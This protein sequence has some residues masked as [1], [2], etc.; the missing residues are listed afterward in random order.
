MGRGERE[1]TGELAH[2]GSWR[3]GEERE[4][5]RMGHNTDS[6]YFALPYGVSA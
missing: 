6:T 2:I 3:W 1:S 4:H 5:V